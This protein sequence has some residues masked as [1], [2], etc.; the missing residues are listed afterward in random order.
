MRKK[1]LYSAFGLVLFVSTFF[2]GEHNH[3]S[4][5]QFDNL[6]AKSIFMQSGNINTV[7]RTDAYFNYDKVTFSGGKAGMIWPAASSQRLTTIFTT[8]IIIGAKSVIS[9]NQKELRLAASMYSTHYTAGNIP[10]IGQV[11]PTSVCNDSAF[12][13]YLVSVT[14]Q[15]LVNG[16]VRTKTAAGRTYTFNYSPWNAWPVNLGAPYVEVN[17]IAGYQPGW[18]ADRPGTGNGNARPS[19]MIFTI[20]MDYTNCTNNIHVSELALPGGT[21]PLGC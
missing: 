7:F 14:D 12:N 15:S 21:L 17:G 18:N 1:V 8:G 4:Y 6:T 11:P 13:G 3:K 5:Q 10:V 19:E 2:S 20:F 16:G 9:G